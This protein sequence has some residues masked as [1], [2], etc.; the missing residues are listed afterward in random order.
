VPEDVESFPSITA[1]RDAF[2]DR[3]ANGYGWF[4]H[5]QYVNREPV[6]ALTPAVE[7]GDEMWLWLYDPSQDEDPYP[8]KILSRGARGGV[9]LERA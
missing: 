4:Q 6:D 7:D 8:W 9:R 5:F 2:T 3:H 1:A